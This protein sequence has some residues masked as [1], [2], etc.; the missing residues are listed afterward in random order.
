[1]LAAECRASDGADAEEAK[2]NLEK[3]IGALRKIK[4]ALSLPDAAAVMEYAKTA[5]A[6]LEW[7]KKSREELE[8]LEKEAAELRRETSRLAMELRARRKE[9]AMALAASVNGHLRELG[10]EYAEAWNTL[11]SE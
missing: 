11:S 4:R 10:M 7:L 9:A 5:A 1:M 8:A 3:R 6:E 2:E